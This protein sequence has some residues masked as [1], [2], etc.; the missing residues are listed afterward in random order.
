VS[1]SRQF[2]IV[3]SFLLLLAAQSAYAGFDDEPIDLDP[4]T[5]AEY[6]HPA[7]DPNISRLFFM[8]TFDV[9]PHWQTSL[10]TTEF[11]SVQ[12]TIGLLGIAQVGAATVPL[13]PGIISIGAKVRLLRLNAGNAGL[14]VGGNYT[15]INVDYQTDGLTEATIGYVVAGYKGERGQVHGGVFYIET[16]DR[17]SVNYMPPPE[18]DYT[19]PNSSKREHAVLGV[20][21]LSAPVRKDTDLMMEMW[22]IGDNEDW[23]VILP[24]FRFFEG[25]T[26]FE[27][28]VTPIWF[29]EG[30]I[31]FSIPIFNITHHFR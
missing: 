22:G 25:N 4:L 3:I 1:L 18:P 24:G 13:I 29:D 2:I 9:P 14:A 19:R 10:G 17:L 26:S 16:L 21:G 11:V 5:P 12:G 28:V 23:P 27:A 8:P 15:T 6:R 30:D 7:T 20:L 31:Q